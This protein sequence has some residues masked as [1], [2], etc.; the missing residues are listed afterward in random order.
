[1][2]SYLHFLTV[3]LGIV[4]GDIGVSPIFFFKAVFSEVVHK[5]L[6]SGVALTGSDVS[7]VRVY[8]TLS[9]LLWVITLTC[10]MKYVI[11]VLYADKNGEGGTWALVSLLP[12]EHE[13]SRLWKYRHEITMLGML[14]ASF[15]LADGII[16]PPIG[17]L[18]AF[19]GL[20]HYSSAIPE[21]AVVGISVGVLFVLIFT[22]RY[23]TSKMLRFYGP[24]W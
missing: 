21:S 17:V 14:A 20:R 10:C 6:V 3:A 23:G 1:P 9:F 18:S 4:F 19:E 22:Q 7:S 11:F 5:K 16:G 12:T 8:G 15:L 24:S 2:K 13:E